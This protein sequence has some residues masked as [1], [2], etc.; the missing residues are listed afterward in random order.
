V[1][2]HCLVREGVAHHLAFHLAVLGVVLPQRYGSARAEE[3][4][5][6]KADE[7]G[8]MVEFGLGR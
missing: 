1:T 5:L 2:K 6:E 4:H 7:H 8:M 3:H